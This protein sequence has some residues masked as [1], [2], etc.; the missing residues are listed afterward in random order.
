MSEFTQLGPA[1]PFFIIS[2]LA[3]SLAFYT[4]HLGFEARFQAPQEEP[5]FAMVGRDATQFMLKVVAQDV[6]P[7]PNPT[8]HPWAPWDA[9]VHVADPDS[10]A[11]EFEGRGVV[12]TRPIGDTEDGLRGFEVADPD[13]YVLF[14]GRPR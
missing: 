5:F 13:G 10:L 4:R 3:D 9:F 7:L 8:R 11:S 2:D 14:F 1:T 6:G 12:F